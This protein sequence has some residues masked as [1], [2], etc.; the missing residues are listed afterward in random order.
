[1]NSVNDKEKRKSILIAK[2]ET[3]TFAKDGIQ[4]L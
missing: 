2:S 4:V 3:Q 1:M